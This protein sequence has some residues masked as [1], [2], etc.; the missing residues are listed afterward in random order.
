MI[1][2]ESAVA[3]FDLAVSIYKSTHVYLAHNAIYGKKAS[4][5][6]FRENNGPWSYE[7]HKLAKINTKKLLFNDNI[8]V[9][10]NIKTILEGLFKSDK[11]YHWYNNNCQHFCV[12]ICEV[13]GIHDKIIFRYCT[14]WSLSRYKKSV[15][16]A[17]TKL[18]D[19]TLV[20]SGDGEVFENEE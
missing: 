16:F 5:A 15:K 20:P 10:E 7:Y 11:P 3:R 12:K 6:K 9:F 1:V 8:S 19:G 4:L 17:E 14:D 2:N 18:E 13:M